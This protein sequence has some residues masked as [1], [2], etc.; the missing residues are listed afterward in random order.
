MGKSYAPRILVEL[1]VGATTY[2]YATEDLYDTDDNFYEGTLLNEPVLR[3]SLLDRFWGAKEPMTVQFRF[4]NRSGVWHSLVNSSELRGVVMTIKYYDPAN[5]GE[6]ELTTEYTEDDILLEDGDTILMESTMIEILARGKIQEYDVREEASITAELN[7]MDV[8]ETILPKKVVNTTDWPKATD[9]G[10][11]VNIIFGRAKNIP[12]PYIHYNFDHDH[13]DYL[14]GYGPIQ[15][16]DLVYRDGAAVS[17]SEYGVYDGSQES[18]YPGYAFIRFSLEQKD[19]G[20]RLYTFTADVQGYPRNFA[21]VIEQILS[22]SAWGLGESVD[23]NSFAGAKDDLNTIGSMYC[24]GAITWE[25]RAKDVID[26]L[27][28]LCRGHLTQNSLGEWQLFIDTYKTDVIA[29]FGH[30]DGYYE[31]ILEIESRSALP[32]TQ[33]YKSVT[34]KYAKN[35]RAQRKPYYE[36]KR[37]VFS[38]GIDKLYETEFVQDHVTA[39]KVT[40]YLARLAQHADNKLGLMVGMDGR[41]LSAQKIISV[42]IPGYSISGNY[43]IEEIEKH[44]EKYNLMLSEY[45]SDIYTHVEGDIPADELA[46]EDQDYKNI[47]PLAP[48]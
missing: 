41:T 48:M 3:E 26:E 33:A 47:H 36:N 19:F 11:G 40:C 38:F 10:V 37:D 1:T 30:G 32:A 20:G 17:A 24:D 8:L 15:A 21:Y 6:T 7:S 25:R 29:S 2:R 16:V 9:L 14:I 31:N 34:L 42:N 45:S 12:L 43:K 28:F 22:D 4:G 44:L 23:K 27:L 46:G 13:Y 35:D 18:P 5:I 39:D